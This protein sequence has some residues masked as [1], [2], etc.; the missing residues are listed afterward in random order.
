MALSGAGWWARSWVNTGSP[1]F[2][3]FAGA[4]PDA[5]ATFLINRTYGLGHGPLAFL[6]LPW[7]MLVGPY[8]A[9]ADP[10]VFGMGG[11]LL[12]AAAAA[13]LAMRRA[14]PTPE[15][16]FL[17]A[18]C[19]A[20]ILLWF[21]SGQVMRYLTSILGL[22]AML[23]MW[24]L[25]RAGVERR[26]WLAR[27]IVCLLAVAAVYESLLMSVLFRRGVLPPVT[28]AQKEFTLA[29]AL[30]YYLAVRE[31]NRRAAPSEKTY[32]LFC[33]ECG[34]YLKTATAGDW[35][36]D[37]PYRWTQQNV[38]SAP[39]LAARL[40]QAGFRWVLVS[41]AAARRSAGI[42]DWPFAES[43]F[44]RRDAVLPGATAVYS[45]NLYGAFRLW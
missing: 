31:I 7:H 27:A 34:Y 42:F 43:A 24:L 30:P 45:D 16:L 1:A 5:V 38:Y 25:S 29:G 4:Q 20:F 22:L 6:L 12:V 35:H 15:V 13:A 32:L 19:A 18:T 23:W 2:P 8:T 41:R 3:F 36:G 26:R 37:Y 9:F 44:V 21:H 14:R 28:Y 17:A 11:L 40:R 10:A 39:D 33:E